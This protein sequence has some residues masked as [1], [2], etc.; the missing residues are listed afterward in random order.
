MPVDSA[1][2]NVLTIAGSDSGGGA[3]IQADLKTFS[4]LGVYGASVITALTAQNTQTVKAVFSVDSSFVSQQIETVFD[5]IQIGAV[6]TGM[7]GNR[8]VIQSVADALRSKNIQLVVDPV[9]ISTSGSV[10]L[11]AE[12]SETLIKELFPLA[13]VVTPNMPEAAAILGSDEPYSIDG[14]KEMARAIYELGPQ[15]VL[16]KGGHMEGTHCLDIFF[17]GVKFWEFDSPKVDTRNTHGTGCTLASAI[18]AFIAKGESLPVAIAE[19]KKYI[20]SALENADKLNVGNGHG[21]V[22][23]FYQF[24]NSQNK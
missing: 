8:S 3:G 2:Q 17:D 15:S 5:D 6:K 10:L 7:L 13:L 22:N 14:M 11:E 21:P 9:M 20:T 16:L 1:L 24:W 18:T 23:H 19:A 12:A 4:A